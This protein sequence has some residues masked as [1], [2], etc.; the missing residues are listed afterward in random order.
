MEKFRKQII[1]FLSYIVII[2]AILFFWE[3]KGRSLFFKPEIKIK[4]VE[5]EKPVFKY[6]KKAKTVKE[7]KD[8]CSSPLEIETK[9][10]NDTT[11]Y[12]RAS[13]NWKMAEQRIK[14][15]NNV[16]KRARWPTFVVG[17]VAV[18]VGF[19]IGGYVMYKVIKKSRR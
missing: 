7:Y 2:A 16:E 4:I 12:I 8:C 11:M 18:T 14:L 19:A 10:I 17:G 3:L 9:M 15:A 5:K 6:I 13:D 1:I